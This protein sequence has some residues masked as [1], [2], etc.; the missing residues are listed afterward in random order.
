MPYRR[1]LKRCRRGRPRL[2]LLLLLL[3][4]GW[5]LF[6]AAGNKPPGQ[7]PGSADLPFTPPAGGPEIAVLM[8]DG[9]TQAW[10]LEEFLPGVV[11]AEMPASFAPEALK[12][13]A[14]AA[15]TYVLSHSRGS[16]GLPRH[17]NA[18][19]CCDSR[20]C[21]A[22]LSGEQLQQRWGEGFAKNYRAISRA[23]SETDGL[24][25]FYAGSLVE[26]PYCSTCGGR[27]QAAAD[28]WG[29]DMPY[30]QSV[31]C[32]WDSH[33]P[34]A[35]SVVDLSLEEAARR[36]AVKT[37]SLAGMN[38]SY[39][40]GGAIS[41]L[42]V[43]AKTLSGQEVR[44]ALG[45]DSAACQWLIQNGRILF[46]TRGFGHG[47]GLCQYGA[48]GLAKAGYTAQQILAY[49]YRGVEISGGV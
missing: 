1:R 8:P 38:A 40:A 5:C 11:A 46:S 36:L 31:P 26:T 37:A 18:D 20:H 21:Q 30:L 27:T 41:S 29:Q 15:R 23:V 13:Q 45:L 43:G 6:H 24:A 32:Y 12:A 25:I 3:L 17:E 9:T 33:S 44:Q 14:I 19:I 7:P 10:P 4:C 48:D 34:R 16:G 28:V 35:T 42:A 49:Y 2:L 22:W 39:S 47:V